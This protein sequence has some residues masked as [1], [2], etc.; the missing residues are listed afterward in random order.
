MIEVVLRQF[1]AVWDHE[2][3]AKLGCWENE[4]VWM[5]SD[6]KYCL[7][8]LVEQSADFKEV[9]QQ[10]TAFRSACY[11]IH[12]AT[13]ITTSRIKVWMTKTGLSIDW[14][15]TNVISMRKIKKKTLIE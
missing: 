10:S 2:M 9:L 7:S 3:S 1:V 12:N 4:V 11:G 5:N 15:L 6:P 8:L 13:S 14:I